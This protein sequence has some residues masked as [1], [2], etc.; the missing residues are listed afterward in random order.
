MTDCLNHSQSA[1]SSLPVFISAYIPPVAYLALASRYD[2]VAV[3]AWENYAK[4]SVRNRAYI[5]SA[6]GILTL[7]VPTKRSADK[8]I[9]I[10]QVEIDN[11]KPWQQNHLRAISSAYG[12]TPYFEFY[13][14]ELE[15]I[16]LS[17]ETG[18]FALNSRLTS[19][20]CRSIGIRTGFTRTS[21]YAPNP[22]IDYRHT[23]DKKGLLLNFHNRSY[24]Q[25]FSNKFPFVENLSTIDLLFNL[26]PESSEYLVL[27]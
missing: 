11:S 20:L 24:I 18:L 17:R 6:N 22:P 19:W 25:A 4:Q 12:K 27:E 13:F 3:E 2:K 8:K 23:F 21:D 16:I 14:P 1:D 7:V 5:L 26:G 9:P 15:S 10:T